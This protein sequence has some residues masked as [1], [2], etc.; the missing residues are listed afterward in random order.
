ME[1]FNTDLIYELYKKCVSN[2]CK[3]QWHPTRFVG[4]VAKTSEYSRGSL[5]QK[6]FASGYFQ[7]IT[8]GPQPSVIILKVMIH[9][10]CSSIYMLILPF[11]KLSQP[12]RSTCRSMYQYVTFEWLTHW[13]LSLWRL[14]KCPRHLGR[15]NWHPHLLNRKE[16]QQALLSHLPAIQYYTPDSM[17]PEARKDYIKWY[18]EHKNDDFDFQGELIRYYQSD[19]DILIKCCLKFR[20]LFMGLTKK[21]GH[22]GIDPFEKVHYH[23]VGMQPCFQDEFP[24]AWEY[25]HHTTTWLSTWG[26]TICHG[27]SM[28]V[29]HITHVRAI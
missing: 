1:H 12:G 17:K 25:S 23:S 21:D 18:Y 6:T 16:N 24:R 7:K 2:A 20:D 26:K 10:P 29:L 5:L 28:A 8:Q 9:T 11:Q 13:T 14:Q 3:V 22:G 19:V 27:V 4:R 15:Q